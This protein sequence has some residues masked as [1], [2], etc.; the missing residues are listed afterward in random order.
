MLLTLRYWESKRLP[1]T[2][3]EAWSNSLPDDTISAGCFLKSL[4]TA[5]H[6]EEVEDTNWALLEELL[7]NPNKTIKPATELG[8]E[9]LVTHATLVAGYLD[10]YLQCRDDAIAALSRSTMKGDLKRKAQRVLHQA[11]YALDDVEEARALL[12]VMS[13][14]L[15]SCDEGVISTRYDTTVSEMTVAKNATTPSAAITAYEQGA[16]SIAE[17]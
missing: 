6:A 16:A 5:G 17:L 10:D 7:Y 8:D 1:E 15:S 9:E 3:K 14:A 13:P 11:Y 12:E 4:H 2:I